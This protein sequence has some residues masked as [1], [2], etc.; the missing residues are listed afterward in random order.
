MTLFSSLMAPTI[1]MTSKLK[2][3]WLVLFEIAKPLPFMHCDMGICV[4]QT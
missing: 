4:P 3:L 2:N 1:G